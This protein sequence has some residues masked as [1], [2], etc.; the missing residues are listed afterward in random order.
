I[1]IPTIPQKII[2]SVF[3]GIQKLNTV[4]G[5][6]LI[7]FFVQN[8]FEQMID[9]HSDYRVVK[10]DRGATDITEALGLSGRKSITNIKEIVHAMAYFEFRDSQIAGNLIQLSKYKSPITGR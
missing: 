1:P 7:R 10:H 9:G 8:A 5:H 3:N 2:S 4:T 6:R